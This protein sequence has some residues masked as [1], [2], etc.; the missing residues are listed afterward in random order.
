MNL[1]S[2]SA[3]MMTLGPKPLN[4]K[5]FKPPN[6]KPRT[7]GNRGGH[8]GIAW[9]CFSLNVVPLPPNMMTHLLESTELRVK[10]KVYTLSFLQL[11]NLTACIK[12]I[13]ISMAR[14]L[15]ATPNRECELSGV[16]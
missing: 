2:P 6:P 5:P 3:H 4:P 1:K 16:V 11:I 7:S 13:C 10:F 15:P 14:S 12:H 8:I 9:A